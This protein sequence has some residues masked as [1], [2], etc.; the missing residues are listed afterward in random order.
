MKEMLSN[1]KCFHLMQKH[2]FNMNPYALLR[3][4]AMKTD[5]MS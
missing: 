3:L 2:E 1:T 5:K 4:S